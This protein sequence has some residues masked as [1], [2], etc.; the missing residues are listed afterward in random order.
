[1]QEKTAVRRFKCSG[2][3]SL[4]NTGLTLWYRKIKTLRIA[5]AIVLLIAAAIWLLTAC[6]AYWNHLAAKAK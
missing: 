4:P 6:E 5:G 2:E 3:N 1:M